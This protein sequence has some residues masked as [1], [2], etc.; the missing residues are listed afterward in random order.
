MIAA[1]SNSDSSDS[2][3][4]EEQVE[5]LCFMVNED[6]IQEEETEYESSD[7]VYY[8]DF[9]EYSKGELARALVKC[10]RCEQGYLSKIKSFKK[11]IPI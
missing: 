6:L 4:E 10:I 11:K 5:S 8:S 9:L 1:W 7:E 2:N 3:D